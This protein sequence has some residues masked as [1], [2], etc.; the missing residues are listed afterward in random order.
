MTLRQNQSK[1]VKM[2]GKLIAW[3]YANGY[4]LTPGRFRCSVDCTIGAGARSFH[5]KGL[6]VD[7]NLFRNG[8]YLRSTKAHRPLGKYWESIGGSWGGH[9]NDGNHYSLGE[10]AKRIEDP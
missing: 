2:L 3:A 5:S 9:W 4:E 10:T 8:R 6:A 1:F 7:L